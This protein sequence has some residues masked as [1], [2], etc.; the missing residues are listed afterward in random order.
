VTDPSP[1]YPVDVMEWRAWVEK[2]LGYTSQQCV[3]FLHQNSFPIIKLVEVWR[4]EFTV[5]K[6]YSPDFIPALERNKKGF[7]LWL[8]ADGDEP[9]WRGSDE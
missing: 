1:Y 5:E 4:R 6:G 8:Y 3:D 2:K 9:F 7:L